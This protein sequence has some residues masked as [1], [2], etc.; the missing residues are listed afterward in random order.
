MGI[1]LQSEMS[2]PVWPADTLSLQAASLHEQGRLSRTNLGFSL[3][4]LHFARCWSWCCGLLFCVFSHL[5]ALGVS[6]FVAGD[7]RYCSVLSYSAGGNEKCPGTTGTSVVVHS[8][9]F[10]H[11]GALHGWHRF[12]AHCLYL[13]LW[14]DMIPHSRNH[15]PVSNDMVAPACWDMCGCIVCVD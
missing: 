1:P 5:Y 7:Q 12:M 8:G 9:Q 10:A 11:V 13:P 15:L 3:V 6:W 2:A 4:G 14:C